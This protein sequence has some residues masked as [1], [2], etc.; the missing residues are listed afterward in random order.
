ML[1]L[2]SAVCV[3]QTQSADL[4]DTLNESAPL[5]LALHVPRLPKSIFEISGAEVI[6]VDLSELVHR[7]GP[8][9]L[10]RLTARE[11][12][13]VGICYA[14][15]NTS[16]TFRAGALGGWK[17]VT[18]FTIARRAPGPSP[19]QCAG[20]TALAA[21]LDKR[22]VTLF[23]ADALARELQRPDLPAGGLL[24][25]ESFADGGR[26]ATRIS[27][28]TYGRS[29]TGRIEWLDISSIIDR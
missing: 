29:A 6:G 15:S 25:S 23:D 27:A 10:H 20:S 11:G 22:T 9:G 3:A 18:G 21:W 8:A 1:V 12:A 19:A 26:Q 4:V 7:H 2:H 28:I 16:I 14:A 17:Q 5:D 13:P 24:V